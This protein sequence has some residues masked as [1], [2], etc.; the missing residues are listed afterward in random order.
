MR[1]GK[2][3]VVPPSA[4]TNCGRVLD[5]ATG[6]AHDHEEDPV[7]GRRECFTVCASCGHVMMFDDD[8]RL[9]DL[10]ADEAVDV[11]GDPRLL[12]IQRARKVIVK[13]QE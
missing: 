1:L 7:P 4:C 10:T 6:V 9:R 8:M 2:D 11:A 3:H 13:P 12:A 5:C